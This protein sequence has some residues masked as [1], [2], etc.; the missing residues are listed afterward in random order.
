MVFFYPV[1][2]GA[3]KKEGGSVTKAVVLSRF[4]TKR[5]SNQLRAASRSLSALSCFCR[6]SLWVIGNIVTSYIGMIV[7]D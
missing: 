2:V 5:A 6:C 7:I 3:I 4:G 1:K